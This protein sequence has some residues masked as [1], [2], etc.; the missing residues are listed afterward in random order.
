MRATLSQ[1]FSNRD[2]KILFWIITLGLLLRFVALPF[3]Q[4]VDSDAVTRIFIAKNWLLSPE[5]ISEGVWLPLHHYFNAIIIW[6][7]G[8]H[9][10]APIVA[11]MLL[12]VFTAIPIYRFTKREISADGA[13]FAALF[14]VLSPVIFRNS[15]HTLSCIPF[16]FFLALGINAL[17]ASI[18]ENNLRQAIYAG[19]FLTVAAGF[20]YEAWLLIAILTG[21]AVC[22]KS[23]KVAAV[24]LGVSVVFPIFWMLGNYAAHDA[25]FYGLSERLYLPT[26]F[27]TI[28][29]RVVYFPLTWFFL[30]SPIV[31]TWL[32]VKLIS[33]AK[34]KKF[35]WQRA[36][37]AI[38]FWFMFIIVVYKAYGGTLLLQHRFTCTLILLSTPFTGLLVEG[39]RWNVLKKGLVGLVLVTILPLSYYWMTVQYNEWFEKDSLAEKVAMNYRLKSV[40]I[41]EAVPRLSDEVV[42]DF[43]ERVNKELKPHSGLILD[44][45]SW[46]SSYFMALHS[47]LHPQNIHQ[48][49][50]NPNSKELVIYV[51][52][53]VD[54]CPTG[55]IVLKCN[56]KFRELFE[57][58]GDILRFKTR[59]GLFLKLTPLIDNGHLYAFKY[60][61][62]EDK[63]RSTHGVNINLCPKE[64]SRAFF[65]M[66]IK[67]NLK[68]YQQCILSSMDNG[69]TIKKELELYVDWF[70]WNFEQ[71]QKKNSESEN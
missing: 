52:K 65:K 43:S 49:G 55:V 39:I 66:R 63:A 18:R 24:F 37:W 44:F 28:V 4:V 68:L 13:W 32:V 42:V 58:K 2:S 8:S 19:V 47:N 45:W 16:C 12:G 9:I 61:K 36:I 64:N 70:V 53:V 10:T 62:V 46:E 69:T 3:A 71:Q 20:R 30:F 31:V 33:R 51:K 5:L 14:Y 23:W 7:T 15:F 40:G 1:F 34:N 60:R 59:G 26:P 25:F 27:E 57:I 67:D 50:G 56:S 17:S 48:V 6:I 11:H 54:K 35:N 21:V 29:L 41:I 38:P 22:L